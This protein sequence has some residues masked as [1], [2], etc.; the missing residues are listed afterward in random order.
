MRGAAA[1]DSGG[2]APFPAGVATLSLKLPFINF[3]EPFDR[4]Y[5]HYKH[6]GIN[7]HKKTMKKMIKSILCRAGAALA[8][9]ALILATCPNQVS[10][11]TAM[12]FCNGD[13]ATPSGLTASE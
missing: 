5:H 1:V 12:I 8:L 3:Y 4:T 11:A 9:G 13:M 2:R 6:R 7:K 10:A